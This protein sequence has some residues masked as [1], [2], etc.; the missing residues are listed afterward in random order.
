M[1]ASADGDPQPLANLVIE[2]VQDYERALDKALAQLAGYPAITLVAHRI[3]HGG[4]RLAAP[5]I[6]TP[7]V[8]AEL[9]TTVPL[10]P[11]HAPASLAG[12]AAVATRLPGVPQVA[13]FDTAFHAQM[14]NMAR[15]LP[16]SA[17]FQREGLRRYG[18]HGLSYEY[19]VSSLAPH[20]PPRLVIA[21]LGN[22]ASLVAVERGRSIDTTMGLTPTGGILMGTR[23]GDLDPG[24]LLYL[25]RVHRLSQDEIADLV[26]REGGLL[27]IGHSADMQT[28]VVRA[29]EDPDAALAIEMF[30]YAVRKAIGAYAAVLGGLDMLVFTGGIGEHVPLIRAAACRGLEPL[31][32]RV[33]EIRNQSNA[34]DLGTGTCAVRVVRTNENLVMARHALMTCRR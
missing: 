25:A 4:P 16:L 22:G 33:D 10:A 18:F 19:V 5:V 6:V 15:R 14:P 12:I 21:H 7:E 23:T 24:L 30:G 2:R 1:F 17:S 29:G 3:V 8:I 11:L 31:G 13:C 9:E 27:A 34:V 28:L 32:V 20:L 26:E